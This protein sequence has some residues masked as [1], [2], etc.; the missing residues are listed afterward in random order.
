MDA[1]KRKI[2]GRKLAVIQLVLLIT[3][4]VT[5]V[6]LA[7]SLEEN[8]VIGEVIISGNKALS[9]EEILTSELRK[10]IDTSRGSDVIFNV[11]NYLK[12]NPYVSDAFVS[13]SGSDKLLVEIKERKPSAIIIDSTGVPG[14]ICSDGTQLPY[15]HM[16]DF[17]NL[18]VIRLDKAGYTTGELV[19]IGALDILNC[20]ERPGCE[21]IQ[22]NIS[23]IICNTQTQTFE[24]ISSGFGIKIHFGTA[25]DACRKIHKLSAFWEHEM[26]VITPGRI[27]YVDVRWSNQVVVNLS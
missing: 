13:F 14:F 8:R 9:Q 10:L 16:S 1:V 22:Q 5:I 27:I 24:L 2:K 6:F 3:A 4:I 21:F 7:N 11:S 17:V 19:G 26:P 25:D 15:G 18:P 23:E 12:K 20:L